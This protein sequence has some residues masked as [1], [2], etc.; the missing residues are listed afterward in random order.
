MRRYSSAIASGSAEI[1]AEGKGARSHSTGSESEIV[2]APIT[3]PH[4]QLV[5][6]TIFY[7]LER[8]QRLLFGDPA[9]ALEWQRTGATVSVPRPLAFIDLPKRTK[10]IPMAAEFT[11]GKVVTFFDRLLANSG[12]RPPVYRPE[13]KSAYWKWFS[14]N[15]NPDRAL[16]LLEAAASQ[17]ATRIE[18]IDFRVPL[19]D[20]V[21]T[22]HV[23]IEVAGRYSTGTFAYRMIRRGHGHGMRVVGA[24]RDGPDV[25]VLGM[26]EK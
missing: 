2:L 18:W 9:G 1:S 23:Q 25:N 12:E 6:L 4:R 8:R 16:G 17:N 20:T 3:T 21:E 7:P 5:Q 13:D 11:N 14:D 19:N 22:M 15:F 26:Y 24:L 10:F